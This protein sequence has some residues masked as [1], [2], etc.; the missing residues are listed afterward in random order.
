MKERGYLLPSLADRVRRPPTEGMLTRRISEVAVKKRQHCIKHARVYG[1]RRIVIK[2]NKVPGIAFTRD[3]VNLHRATVDSACVT[4]R[5]LGAGSGRSD[6]GV[7]S[8]ER[9]STLVVRLLS[10]PVEY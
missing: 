8:G 4:R 7:A 9:E 3:F 1:S 6:L 5:V 10:P 2:I